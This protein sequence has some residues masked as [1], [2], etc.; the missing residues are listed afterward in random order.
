MDSQLIRAQFLP[1]AL[2]LFSRSNVAL[3]FFYALKFFFGDS[4]TWDETCPELVEGFII[5]MAGL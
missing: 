5:G 2:R 1:H 3:Q 4:L